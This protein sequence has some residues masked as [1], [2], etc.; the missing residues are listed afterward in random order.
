MSLEIEHDCPQCGGT[1][2]FWRT[3][4]TTLHLGLKT[5]WQCSECDYALVR[6]N[7]DIDSAA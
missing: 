2:T 4:S 6:I 3:A 1:E 5:K 7:G